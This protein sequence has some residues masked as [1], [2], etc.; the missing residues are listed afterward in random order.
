[1]TTIPTTTAMDWICEQL[2]KQDI[3][4]IM[5]EG[6]VSGAS[7]WI[8]MGGPRG[9]EEWMDGMKARPEKKTRARSGWM[10]G[11]ALII[12][13]NRKKLRQAGV[14]IGG[15]GGPVGASVEYDEVALAAGRRETD[16]MAAHLSIFEEYLDDYAACIRYTGNDKTVICC[17]SDV[18][19]KVI[20]PNFLVDDEL[21]RW[22][23]A[24][25]PETE[26]DIG[27]GLTPE[28][29]TEAAADETLDFLRQWNPDRAAQMAGEEDVA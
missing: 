15:D 22:C 23:A 1:M 25:W 21:C 3:I 29:Y 18:A 10:M 26:E 8:R 27:L 9:K 19:Y 7:L 12:E 4:E 14:E 20:M 16:A 24:P 11:A 28:Q 13:V 5:P 2:T 6:L 17:K